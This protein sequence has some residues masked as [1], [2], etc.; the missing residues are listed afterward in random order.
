MSLCASSLYALSEAREAS[1][2][3]STG[4]LPSPPTEG[5]G[6]PSR[7]SL[8]DHRVPPRLRGSFP[9]LAEWERPKR[10]GTASPAPAIWH[11]QRGGE[12]EDEQAILF[13]PL[14][15]V[16]EMRLVLSVPAGNERGP[17][18]MDQ[19]LAA[20]H[21]VN[22]GRLPVTL[23]MCRNAGEVALACRC[24]GDF[25][26]IVESQL[27]AQYP[28]CHIAPVTRERT[29]D[30]GL[31]RWILELHLHREL[32]PIKRFTQF[33]DA[34][35]RVSSDPITALLSTLAEDRRYPTLDSRIEI[36]IRPA[37]R[38]VRFRAVSAVHRLAGPFFRPHHLLAH[39]H[40]DWAM[41]HRLV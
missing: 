32:F 40:A 33:E 17:Q 29:D 15:M 27:Y 41:A 4:A 3:A 21:Q 35:N 30:D 13:L 22:R 10:L 19:A 39:A 16:L 14:A 11:D 9:S 5:L 36:V 31:T 25:R 6:P 20:L 1:R 24:P 23:E 8:S 2:A 28:D 34:L 38:W 26:Y 12:K 18:Y 7:Q 37:A